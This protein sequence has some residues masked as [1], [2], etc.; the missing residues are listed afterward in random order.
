[1]V[2]GAFALMAD[3]SADQA[4]FEKVC[5]HCHASSL[6]HELKTQGEWSETVDN[7]AAN[8][9]KGT[10][11][12]FDAVLRYLARNFTKVN[13]NAAG[14]EE[15]APVLDVSVAVAQGIVDYRTGHGA[16]GSLEDLKKV[17]GLDTAKVVA[18]RERIAFR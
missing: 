10:D 14:A 17:P 16:F 1:M 13:I 3:D 6:I 18:R 15:I 2:L 5:G 11:E 8:G 12:E 4:S 9:A 7:M